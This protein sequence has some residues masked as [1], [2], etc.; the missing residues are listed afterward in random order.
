MFNY[1]ASSGEMIYEKEGFEIKFRN[2]DI[3]K[4]TVVKSRPIAEDTNVYMGLLQLCNNRVEGRPG[5]EDI[6]YTCI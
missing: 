4:I 2:A 1:N 3:Q 5:I 6:Q